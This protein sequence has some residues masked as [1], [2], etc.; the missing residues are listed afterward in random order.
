MG[1]N[2]G[3]MMGGAADGYR[4][5]SEDMRKQAEEK[6]KQDEAD[7]QEAYRKEVESYEPA[8]AKYQKQAEQHK[9]AARNAEVDAS[10]T[11]TAQEVAPVTVNPA[12]QGIKLA[13]ATF[14]ADTAQR[15][16]ENPMQPARSFATNGITAADVA[17][18]GIARPEQKAMPEP[19]KPP[20]MHDEL[21]DIVNLARIDVKYGK[22]NAASL[23][24]LISA[25]KQMEDEGLTKAL[26]MA[27]S[28][29]YEGAKRTFESTGAI[30]DASGVRFEESMFDPGNGMKPIKSAVAVLPD[31]R[32][33]D[34]V[35]ALWAQEQAKDVLGNAIK[36]QEHGWKGE[37]Q[38]RKGVE[39][40]AKI[41]SENAQAAAHYASAGL[42]NA[43]AKNERDGGSSESAPAEARLVDYYINKHGMTPEAAR[44]FV[45]SSKEGTP[46]SHKAKLIS[47]VSANN[48][49]GSKQ[50]VDAIRE[51]S[52]MIDALFG[53]QQEAVIRP[54][55]SSAL[56]PGAKQVGTSG[57]KPVYQTPDGKRFI[58]E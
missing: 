21:M 1:F 44:K 40:T 19:P 36:M 7:R 29:D 34:A 58:G 22:A 50:K 32:R 23:Y 25:V 15:A 27:A 13:P 33:L 24:P 55:G 3:M 47:S 18:A 26:R 41:G 49:M 46:E 2:L 39:T 42:S 53:T 16:V 51:G 10:T 4:K 11:R 14:A 30:R 57:G 54:G 8:Q 37:E 45:K 6:R 9:G 28:G 12:A 43:K 52:A 38:A 17:R 56:P 20:G 48:M 31:G 5:Q 35:G